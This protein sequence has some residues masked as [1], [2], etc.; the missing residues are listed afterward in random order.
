[1]LSA[2]KRGDFSGVPICVNGVLICF[3][4]RVLTCR[5]DLT[6]SECIQKHLTVGPSEAGVGDTFAVGK[7]VRGCN[8]LVT[9][10]QVTL[11]HHT[12]NR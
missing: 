7:I 10:N 1:M 2:Q 8:R 11:N 6:V 12:T 4:P 5:A 9:A 3:A